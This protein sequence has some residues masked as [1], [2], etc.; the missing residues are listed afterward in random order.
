MHGWRSLQSPLAVFYIVLWASAYVPSTIGARGSPPLWFLVAR[1][2]MAAVVMGA[3]AVACK[4]EFPRNPRTWLN[5]ALI[6]V[7]ANAAY[8][9]FTYAA[10]GRGLASGM[11]SIV[12][13]TNPLILALIAP[14]LLGDGLSWRKGLGL[15]LGFGGVLGVMLARA[16]PSSARPAE[17]GLAFIGVCSN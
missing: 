5:Y 10:L 2:A 14:T 15:V 3:I 1:F 11:G 9:G 17:V 12:A 7:T 4:R 8:L 6:G 16:D 13:S